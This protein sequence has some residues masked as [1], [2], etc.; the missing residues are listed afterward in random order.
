MLEAE[1]VGDRIQVWVDGKLQVVWTDPARTYIRGHFGIQVHDRQTHVQIRKLEVTELDPASTPDPAQADGFYPLFNGKDLIGWQIDGGQPSAWRVD[2]GHL[3][4]SGSG[5]Y[6]QQTFLL[7]EKSY[8]DF[9]LSF[10]F[11]FAGSRCDS[12]VAIRAEPGEKPSPLEINL[13]NF[14]DEHEGAQERTGAIRWSN[15]GRGVDYLNPEQSNLLRPIPSWNEMVVT[16][17]GSS[18]Q[19][20]LNGQLVQDVD[21]ER[22]SKRPSALTSLK[23]ASGRVGFQSHTG[24][25]RFRNIRIK[26]DRGQPGSSASSLGKESIQSLSGGAKNAK[27]HPADAIGHQG[28]FY[29]VFAGHLSW[30][31]AQAR[32]RELGGHLAVVRDEYTNRFLTI[33]V[34][35]E[36]LGGAWL[37]ATDERVEKRWVWVDGTPMNYDNWDRLRNQPN[38]K[39]GLEHYAV[40][41][42]RFNGTWCDQPDDGREERPGFICQWD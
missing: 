13:R 37:G 38:N 27:P 41:L 12:G 3:I 14:P 6:R 24:E 9:V 25:V 40:L 5:D 8:T 16:A 2:D 19:V 1:A 31:E 20:R 15:S 30:H 23:R 11:W 32:C 34:N 28:H 18:V 39:Q 29:K 17:R 10:E 36:G 33:Q 21:L 35:Q 42:T 22:L 4:A 26:E 7:S